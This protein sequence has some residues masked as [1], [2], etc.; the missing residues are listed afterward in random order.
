LD[1]FNIYDQGARQLF[2]EFPLQL[3]GENG[4]QSPRLLIVGIAD[5]SEQ[6][7][8]NAAR[9]WVLT[10]S[11]G[12]SK[13]LITILDPNAETQIERLRQKY[14]L[15]DQYCEWESLPFD[16]N[17]V[18]FL[19]A[20][21]L[22]R[23]DKNGKLSM[24]YVMTEDES[25][26]LC[27]ALTL[28]EKLKQT[29]V[30]ILVRMNEERGLASLI[31]DSSKSTKVYEKLFLFGL[32]E[33]TCRMCLIF[34]SSH[35]SIARA[36][37]EDYLRREEQK[38]NLIGSTPILV[39]WDQLPENFQEMNRMQ[40][41][42][43]GLKLKA[44]NCEIVPWVDFGAEEFCFSSNEIEYLAKMEHERWCREKQNQ[45]WIYGTIR[46]DKIKVHPSLIPYE[47]PRLS[48]DEKD[49]DRNTVR[50]IPRYLALAGYQIYREPK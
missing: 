21:F 2:R 6:L 11:N 7:I 33:R 8:L 20:D 23:I 12:S 17:S 44:I 25:I 14:S 39:P 9:L 5:F 31:K 26:G 28:L 3:P 27:S 34:N 36:I 1:I 24:V 49:K 4:N 37:H 32:M 29:P 47:D 40:A 50:Q 43:I 48:E 46:D 45:G 42:D 15:I 22:S 41:D 18:D 35:E 38:G 30:R 16:T 10:G 13:L 19:K